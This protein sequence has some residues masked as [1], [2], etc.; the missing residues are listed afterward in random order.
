MLDP[1][2]AKDVSQKRELLRF[3]LHDTLKMTG[4][5]PQ[6]LG[7]EASPAIDEAGRLWIEV[8]LIIECDEPRFFQYLAAFQAEFESR[9]LAIDA[10][11]W[12]WVSRISWSLATRREAGD[13]DF[14]LPP[15]EHWQHVL[16][17]REITA[18]QQ[19]RK[20][21]DR[22]A[23]ARHFEDTDPGE[24]DFENTHPPQWDEGDLHP[25]KF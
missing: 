5:P 17:D 7:G 22:D 1:V 12:H 13:A 4:I 23:L 10:K 3:V 24:I 8:R 19:G 11:A 16:R 14:K 9:L 18:R 25:S 20:E 6:W 21:W 2:V 15:P